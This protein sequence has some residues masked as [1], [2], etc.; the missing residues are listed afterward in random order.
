MEDVYYIWENSLS[1]D[2]HMMKKEDYDKVIHDAHKKVT[3]CR[4]NGFTSLD[5]V[6]EYVRKYSDVKNI[7]RL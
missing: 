6:E 2:F 4:A 7:V 5:E 1:H 3:F